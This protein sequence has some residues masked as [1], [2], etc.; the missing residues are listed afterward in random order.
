MNLQI[1]LNYGTI[2]NSIPLNEKVPEGD[3][4]EVV[5][6]YVPDGSHRG[7]DVIAVSLNIVWYKLFLSKYEYATTCP[8]IDARTSPSLGASIGV[9]VAEVIFNT[10]PAGTISEELTGDAKL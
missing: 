5:I 10:L 1:F 6:W 9:T 3:E 8:S 7:R 2:L 4:G